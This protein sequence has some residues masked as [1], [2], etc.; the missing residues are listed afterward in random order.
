[1][2][3]LRVRGIRLRLALALLVVVAGSLGVVYL[4]VVPSIEAEL[5]DAKLN[6]LEEDARTVVRAYGNDIGS[7][8]EFAEDA[9]SVVQARVVIYS[10]LQNR[11]F[12][13]GD[14]NTSQ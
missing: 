11:L 8:Q 2:G 14:S 10:L 6:Q 3:R 7:E 13:F 1:M 4:I 5:I 12:I 9:A